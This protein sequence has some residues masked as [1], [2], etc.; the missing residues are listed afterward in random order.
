[1]IGPRL[2]IGERFAR[3]LIRSSGQIKPRISS[4]WNIPLGLTQVG[5]SFRRST[6]DVD[7]LN[8]VSD[9]CYLVNGILAAL[10]PLAAY[11]KP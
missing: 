1:M 10:S 9:P 7:L 5:C 2:R 8:A 3:D 4:G 6:I 11:S